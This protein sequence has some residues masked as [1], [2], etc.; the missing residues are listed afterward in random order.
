MYLLYNIDVE[1]VT[2]SIY[3]LQFDF[4]NLSLCG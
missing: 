1:L 2:F 4:I 3:M